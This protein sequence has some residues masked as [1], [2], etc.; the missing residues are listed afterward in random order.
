MRDMVLKGRHVNQNK[1][2]THCKNGHEFTPENTV[3]S[4]K[5]RKC[6]KC[7]YA[8]VNAWDMRKRERARASSAGS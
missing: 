2:K 4:G 5:Q 7:Y 1:G 6:K 8:Y 3:M